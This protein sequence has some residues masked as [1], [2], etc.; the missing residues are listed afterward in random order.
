MKIEFDPQTDA[1]YVRL[2]ENKVVESEAINPNVVLDFDEAGNVV[3]IEILSVSKH[4]S[5]PLKK[6]A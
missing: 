6:A 1:L 2:N 4:D 5:L 3:S